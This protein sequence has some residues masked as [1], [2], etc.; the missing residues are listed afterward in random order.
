MW[1]LLKATNMRT[2]KKFTFSQQNRNFCVYFLFHRTKTNG[3]LSWNFTKKTHNSLLQCLKRPGSETMS[4][5]QQQRQC[6][7]EWMRRK[8]QNMGGDIS[9][10]SQPTVCRARRHIVDNVRRKESHRKEKKKILYCMRGL[11]SRSRELYGIY[12]MCVVYWVRS[13]NLC[14][15]VRSQISKRLHVMLKLCVFIIF[16]YT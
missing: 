12:L 14:V 15:S 7:C 16:S 6:C 9:S 3:T 1:M 8:K 4:R 10:C 13:R 11:V 5:Q 2:A